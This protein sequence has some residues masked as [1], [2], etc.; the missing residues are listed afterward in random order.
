M[1]I[2]FES[3]TLHRG[4]HLAERI[5][6]L[7]NGRYL[8]VE[9]T[10][11]DTYSKGIYLCLLSSTGIHLHVYFL[12]RKL[13]RSAAQPKAFCSAHKLFEMW[14]RKRELIEEQDLKL[15]KARGRHSMNNSFQVSADA[16]EP[17]PAKVR[18][19]EACHDW[20]TRQLPFHI[21]V[22]NRE[23]KDHEGLQL[24]HE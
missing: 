4:E 10:A 23:Y 7:C 15:L 21:E 18:K 2:E 19:C 6:N 11:E 16:L 17:K 3:E 14:D 1:F 5:E 12:T 20:R 8:P 9:M 22:A 24:W 13:G